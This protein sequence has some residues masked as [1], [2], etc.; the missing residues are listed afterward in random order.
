M[1]TMEVRIPDVIPSCVVFLCIKGDSGEA[2]FHGTAFYVGVKSE[3]ATDGHGWG[4]LV[5]A[6]HNV[7]RALEH[8]GE[9]FARVNLVGEGSQLYKL[10]RSWSFPDDDASDVAMIRVPPLEQADLSPISDSLFA[11]RQ[12]VRDFNIGLGDEVVV[13]GLFTQHA[14]RQRNVPFVRSGIIAAMPDE[15]LQDQ[16][17]GLDYHGYLVELRSFGGL[18]GSPIFVRLDPRQ[19]YGEVAHGTRYYL[20]GLMRGHWEY[21]GG[22]VAFSD[23]DSAALNM[24]VGI[25]TPVDDLCEI[26]FSAEEEQWR[27]RA[28]RRLKEQKTD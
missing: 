16:R 24:G 11:T 28:D 6:R 15:P 4:Y 3:S 26:L 18:S 19:A 8:H 23:D 2:K 10:P 1:H 21:R 9:L 27:R 13:T 12:R 22:P 5:T 25:V 20:L 14:G 17:S 7:E